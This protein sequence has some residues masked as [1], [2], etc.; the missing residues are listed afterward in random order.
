M[1]SHV[2]MCLI[3]LDT[4][5]YTPACTSLSIH[6][7]NQGDW[8]PVCIYFVF[9]LIQAVCLWHHISCV[10]PLH[11]IE[12]RVSSVIAFRTP[13]AASTSHSNV[14]KSSAAGCWLMLTVGAHLD[15]SAVFYFKRHVLSRLPVAE[16][17][18]MATVADG[19]PIRRPLFSPPDP[20]DLWWAQAI[21]RTVKMVFCQVILL[22]TKHR[23][24]LM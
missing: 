9:Y 13:V 22:F 17:W 24:F 8:Q 18:V 1:F 10:S 12:C 19:P 7:K 3:L 16:P 2:V 20:S 14:V 23:L 4:K 15:T 5:S 6:F 11:C 21:T